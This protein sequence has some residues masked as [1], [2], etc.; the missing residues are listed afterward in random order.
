MA[1]SNRDRVGRGFEDLARGLEPF[2]DL[3]MRRVDGGGWAE[4]FA[5]SG[6]HPRAEYST[7]D[8]T[9][10]LLVLTARWDQVF[11]AQLPPSMRA[12]VNELRDVRNRW[13][14]NQPF[15]DREAD[16]ALDSISFLLEAVDAR[17]ADSVRALQDDLRRQIYAKEESKKEAATS[18]VVTDSPQGLSPWRRVLLPH[19]DVLAGP[20]RFKVAEFAADL[21]LVRQQDAKAAEEYRDPLAFFARTYLTDGLRALLVNALRRTS[22]L[23]GQ[24]IYNCQTNFGGG[25]THSLIALYHL[26]SGDPVDR[27]PA[28]IR[29]LAEG[30]VD[31]IPQ[32]RRAVVVGNRFGVGHI[33]PKPDGTE[34]RTIWGEIAW[35]LG[36]AFDGDGAAGYAMVADSDRTSTSPGDLIRSV[37]ERY[38]PCLILIDEWVAYARELYGRSDLPGGSFETQFSFAQTLAEAARAVD[39]VM[40]VVSIPAS[41]PGQRDASEQLEV[42][43]L[44]VGGVAGVEATKRLTQ[45]VS[46]MAEHWKPAKGDETFEIV[47]RRLFQPLDP[48]RVADRDAVAKAFGE[49]YRKNRG[50]FPAECA[51]LRYEERIKAAYPIHPELF[52]RLHL[53][54]STIERFQRTRGVLRLMAAVI[55][56][57]WVSDDQS[58][59]IMPCSVPLTAPIVNAELT[60]KLGELWDS[61]IDSDVD[62]VASRP[63]QIDRD[64]PNLGRFHATRRVARTIFLGATPTVRSPNRGL[65]LDRIRLGSCLPTES[66]HVFRDALA[67]LADQ[68]SHL[69][70]DRSRYWFDLQENVIRTARDEAERLLRGSKEEVHDEIVDRLRAEKASGEFR[71]VHAAPRGSQDVA[72]EAAARLVVLGPESPHIDK[73]PESPALL[74]ARDLLDH[75]GT[76]P[77]QY[78]NMVVFAAADQRRLEDLERVTADYLAWSGI[79]ERAEEK[80]L[81]LQQR[82]QAEQRRRRAEDAIGLRLAEAYQWVLVPRQPDPVGPVTVDALRLDTQGTVAQRVS[83]ELVTEGELQL[84]FA[85]VLLRRLFDGPLA[86]LWDSGDVAVKDLWETLATYVYLPR[87]RDLDAL[88]TTVEAGPATTD[89]PSA[90]FAVALAVDEASGHYVGLKAGSRPGPVPPT[91][92]V[93]SPEFALGQLE[94]EAK[95]GRGEGLGPT[96]GVGREGGGLEI[97]RVAAERPQETA[98]RR[99]QGAIDLDPRRLNRDFATLVQEVIEHF[100]ALVDAD[101]TVTVEIEAT[102]G[103]GFDDKLRRDVTENA[104]V[105]KFRPGSGFEER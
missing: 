8:P 56:A 32:V 14:H 75:R 13:A 68:A 35:Q 17:E 3:H 96:A 12:V 25:K 5:R 95:A 44:E 70:V 22:G 73:D 33:H 16:R 67:R 84:Q 45:A 41:T 86:R 40:L 2:I 7:S 39:G 34:V 64:N 103:Q 97:G 26:F 54:W 105:L 99:F 63:A 78:R 11:R 42:S 62:G 53:D 46:R 48:D 19:Q 27:F 71:R 91:A 20:E 9:F 66:V 57:L 49:L 76:V 80:Q 52:D 82:Q 47:R 65:E 72:D 83:R 43:D 15:R 90:G 36:E 28:E 29:D 50:E 51:E 31:D 21:E 4:R 6:P 94:V 10:Q 24:P 88:L 1:V 89:W 102:S 30:V 98:Y 23:G 74:Q 101:V 87:L 85:P 37:F 79:L 104:R 92:V 59:L 38:A 60:A 93:V 58:P 69:Y 81:E 18:S 55:H 100:T 77:R 61:V